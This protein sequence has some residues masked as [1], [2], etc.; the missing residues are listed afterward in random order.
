MIELNNI[1]KIY[2]S[3]KAGRV[4][5]LDGISLRFPERGMVFVVGKS[6]SG[7]STLLNILGLLDGYDGGE[8][9]ADGKDVK[10]LKGGEADAYRSANVGFVFQEFNLL[11][12][13]TVRRNVEYSLDLLG[14][15]DNAE[16]VEEMLR[17]VEMEEYGDRKPNELSGGQRQ[18]VAIARAAVKEPKLLLCD[19]PTG[20]LDE[21]TGKSIFRLLKRQSEKSLVVV[22]THD[23][24]SAKEFAD[25]IIELKGGKVAS[26]TGECEGAA[27]SPAS[28]RA[29]KRGHISAR[30]AF[31]IGTG[32]LKTRPIRLSIMLLLCLV[33]FVV[34]G[35][36]SSLAS[37]DIGDTAYRA[38]WDYGTNHLVFRKTV[39]DDESVAPAYFTQDDVWYF[40]DELGAK[41]VD[42]VLPADDYLGLRNYGF[43][44]YMNVEDWSEVGEKIRAYTW[45]EY[46]ME[47]D[48]GF[49]DDYGLRL[50]EESRLPRAQDEC[51]ISDFIFAV[52]DQYDYKGYGEVCKIDSV[53]DLLGKRIAGRTVVGVLETGFDFDRYGGL[54]DGTYEEKPEFIISN[55]SLRSVELD[56]EMYGGMYSYLFLADGYYEDYLQPQLGSLQHTSRIMVPFRAGGRSA[57]KK[58]ASLLKR[59]VDYFGAFDPINP[60]YATGIKLEKIAYNYDN[61]IALDL[62][63]ADSDGLRHAWMVQYVAYFFLAVS[64][65]LIFYYFSGAVVDKKREAGILRA[66][67]TSKGDM[68]RIYAAANGVLAAAITVAGWI[69]AGVCVAFINY[70][71]SYTYEL[72]PAF[73]AFG[74]WQFALLALVAFASVFVGIAV[75]A[76]KM[77]RKRPV[78]M[79]W[80]R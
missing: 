1:T 15:R 20:S 54:M 30:N 28:V 10:L 36:A 27:E 78:D 31:R 56:K 65:L 63:R 48:E 46:F 57:A 80:D 72:V 26:D 70:V 3:K 49:L 58:L 25:R 2:R 19:E 59:D 43:D 8:M 52:F 12:G 60:D 14:K 64:V 37:Y 38:M 41:R 67:G 40:E 79:I 33:T 62:S 11:D 7:K 50:T 4:K 73:I 68:C 66:L 18:R 29:G 9:L 42:P 71:L 75:P 76:W 13:Y 16:R 34:L 44:D 21:E 24:D 77:L 53:S 69:G 32:Y 17:Q 39:H 35:T 74:V 6:G 5:A 47:L 61:G 23:M 22:V 55:A 45:I 51:V